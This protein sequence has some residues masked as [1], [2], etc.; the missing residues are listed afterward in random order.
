MRLPA[1]PSLSFAG[2]S[3]AGRPTQLVTYCTRSKENGRREIGGGKCVYLNLV[4]LLWY[5]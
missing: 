1:P 5:E 4:G 2:D 3:L